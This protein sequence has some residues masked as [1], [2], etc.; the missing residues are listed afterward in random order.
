MK[1][2]G[3]QPFDTIDIIVTVKDEADAEWRSHA[4]FQANRLGEVDP[5]AAAPLKGTYQSKDQMGLFW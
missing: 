2:S 5:A 1:I 3:L 4:V